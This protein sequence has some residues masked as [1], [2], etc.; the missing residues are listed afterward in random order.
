M[1]LDMIEHISAIV[2]LLS[3]F[4]SAFV[5]MLIRYANRVEKKLD[6]IGSAMANT[7]TRQECNQ[8]HTDLAG[9]FSA[10]VGITNCKTCG[11]EG[12]K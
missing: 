5:F 4:A 11:K 2:L 12:D 10:I 6:D 3:I 7:V 8:R 1:Y 9:Y